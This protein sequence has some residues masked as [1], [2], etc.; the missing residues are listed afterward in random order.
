MPMGWP[1]LCKE[2]STSPDISAFAPPVVVILVREVF[3]KVSAAAFA[4]PSSG[5]QN[6]GGDLSGAAAFDGLLKTGVAPLRTCARPGLRHAPHGFQGSLKALLPSDNAPV[7][8]PPFPEV[9]KEALPPDEIV[10][11]RRARSSSRRRRAE[12]SP[13]RR[14]FA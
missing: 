5:F 9:F 13:R 7:L 12:Q 11:Q 4:P 2:A 1:V 6:E 14:C 8:P 3:A 10:S